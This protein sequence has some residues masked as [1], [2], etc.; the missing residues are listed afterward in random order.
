MRVEAI[1]RPHAA[2]TIDLLSDFVARAKRHGASAAEAALIKGISFSVSHRMGARED[3]VRSEGGGVGVRV[4]FGKRQ[5]MA[6]SSELTRDSLDSLLERVVAIARVSPEDPYCGLAEV[7]QLATTF[8]DLELNDSHEPSGEDL[9]ALAAETEAAALAVPGIVNSGGAGANWGR[10]DL[11]LVTSDGFI[12]SMA[13]SS[14]GIGVS[15]MAG[16]D[17][18]MEMDYASSGSHFRADLDSPARVGTEAGERAVR[19]LNP[20]KPD[21]MV[22][23]IVYEPRVAN[24]LLG[25]L[26]GAINGLGIARGSSFLLNDLNKL[27][28]GPDV[29]IVDD[30]LRRRGLGSRPFDAEGVTSKR[31]TLVDKG[32]LKTWM[33]STADA[34]QLGLRSTGHAVRGLGSPPGPSPTNLYLEPGTRTPEELMAGIRLGA[35][36]TNLYGDGIDLLTGD[37]SVGAAGFLIEDGKRTVPISEFTIAANL[38]DMFRNLVPAND[39]VFRYGFDAPTIRIDG[40][41]VGGA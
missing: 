10:A 2:Q 26:A 14:F 36:V 41:T 32:V 25:C 37:Y 17:A 23:P 22:M 4:F 9:F 24:S 18:A 6:S 3:T 5:A 12:G 21:S 33:L 28:F 7:D 30:P 39:L 27:I 13:S 19:R 38:R 34:R 29:T 31:L 1:S 11:T 15:V 8:P 35:Y 40:M 16:S 20:R